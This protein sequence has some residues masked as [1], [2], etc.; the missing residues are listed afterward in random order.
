MMRERICGNE[1]C[2]MQRKESNW[3]ELSTTAIGDMCMLFMQLKERAAGRAA[4]RAA[5]YSSPTLSY[6]S[7]CHRSLSDAPRRSLKTLTLF[8]VK[9]RPSGRA[10]LREIGS[11][12]R[13]RKPHRCSSRSLAKRSMF[14]VLQQRINR[15]QG[16]GNSS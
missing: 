9:D 13:H 5:C 11:T 4:G 14:T 12:R 7:Y 15:R 16:C 2:F 1:R 8:I 10:S 3:F 6:F